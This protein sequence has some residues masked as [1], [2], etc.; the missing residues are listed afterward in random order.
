M[1]ISDTL[2]FNG[3]SQ[4]VKEWAKETGLST[5][6]IWRRLSEQ[7]WT[8][9]EAL[10][11]P[12]GTWAAASYHTRKVN[13][14]QKGLAEYSVWRDMRNRCYNE[15]TDRY[16]IYGGRGITVCDRWRTSFDAFLE[17][18]GPRPSEEHSID[19]IDVNGNYE[20]ANCRWATRKEQG[21]NRRDNRLLTWSN[22]TKTLS[23]WSEETGIEPDTIT[24]RLRR[25]WTIEATL[26][27]PPVRGTNQYKEHQEDI[28]LTFNGKRKAVKTWA[29]ETGLNTRVIL[30]RLNV[31]GW[32]IEEALTRPIG[33]W[34]NLLRVG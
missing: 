6:V 7:D 3:K 4:T 30:R 12:L 34:R 29:K 2:T 18:M 21:R 22:E 28:M 17:D 23:A 27:T 5:R 1:K 9:E 31:Q 8:I 24:E 15:N 25:G 11:Q 13:C 33:D 10:T 16:D 19:R 14:R 20:P 26:T 32:T